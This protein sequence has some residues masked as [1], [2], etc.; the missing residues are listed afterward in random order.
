MGFDVMCIGQFCIDVIIGGA[1]LEHFATTKDEGTSC[2]EVLLSVGGDAANEAIGIAHMGKNVGVISEVQDDMGGRFI[3]EYIKG[4]GVNTDNVKMLPPGPVPTTPN[5]VFVG[6]DA[7]RKFLGMFGAFAAPDDRKFEFD[8]SALDGLKVLSFATIGGYPMAGDEGAEFVIRAA[9]RAKASGAII[10]ADIGAFMWNPD[11]KVYKEMF[12]Q[13][14]YIFPNEDEAFKITRKTTVEDA[15]EVFLEAGVGNAVIKTG[16]DGCYIKTQSGIS[17][18]VP[19]YLGIKAIDTTG[20]GDNFAAGFITALV[21]GQDLEGCAKM[22]NAAASIAVSV[23]GANSG[24]KSRE[25]V[26][27]VIERYVL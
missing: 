8:E 19:T 13:I 21:E 1:D 17:M 4:N 14:D 18:H 20:A 15:A 22:G 6:S 11:P 24:V 25:Q 10:C 5:L 26:Q 12:S 2:D 27:S 7:Q 3:V 9:R 16:A 23:Y